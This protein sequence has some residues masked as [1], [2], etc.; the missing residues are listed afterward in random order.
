MED[1]KRKAP[2]RN[3]VKYPGFD[4]KYTT[5]IRQE[6]LDS[7]EYIDQLNEEEK[8]WMNRF[9]E[10]ELNSQFQNDGTDFNKTKEDRKKIYDR[11]NAQNRDLYGNLKNKADKF[12]N[13][14]LL[15]YDNVVGEVENELNRWSP[16]PR[17]IEN[18]YIDFIESK[19][20][21]AMLRE[22]EA[23][24]AAFTEASIDQQLWQ[25]V[26]PESPELSES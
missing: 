19:E 6:Y 14:K 16:D 10:E 22:Y 25:Q 1:K 26:T 11:N 13:K 21:E 7:I 3:K 4:K 23:A 9:L 15:N 12:S 24:M 18:T 17:H 8:I 2:I 20:I 5:R